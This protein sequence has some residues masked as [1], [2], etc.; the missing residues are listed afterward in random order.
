LKANSYIMLAA[1]TI[2]VSSSCGDE[3]QLP[4]HVEAKSIDTYLEHQELGNRPHLKIKRSGFGKEFILYGSYIPTLTSP[5]SF[6]LRSRI[7]TFDVYADRVIMVESPKGHS[8]AVNTSPILLAEFPI[9]S[10]DADGVIVDFGRGM[11]SAFTVRNVHA[12]GVSAKDSDTSEQFKA[13]LLSASFIKSIEAHEDVLAI[14]QIAQWH[15]Q[16]SELI[17]AEF[18]Y[19]LKEYSQSPQFKKTVYGKH[20][21]VQYFSTP[22]MVKPPTTIPL[23][24]ITKWDLSKP[25][26]FHVSAN[27]P[28]KYK[29]AI[30]D[31][32]LFWNRIFGRD[33]IQVRDLDPAKSAPDPKLNIIQWV[34]WDN[35]ASAYADMVIDHLT[36][37]I[38]QAQIYVR[39]GWVMQSPQKLRNVLQ[40]LF[41]MDESD[42]SKEEEIPI[43]AVFDL[44]QPCVKTMTRS[45]EA[46]DLAQILSRSEVSDETMDVLTADILRAVMAH[47]MGHVLGLRHNLAGSTQGNISLLQRE[48]LLKDYLHTG[49]YQEQNRDFFSRSIM[50]VFS[51]ADDA[52]VGAQI[53]SLLH[54]QARSSNQIQSIYEWDRQAVDFA[55]ANIPMRGNVAFCTDDDM[56]TYQDCQRWD[57][58]HT[59]ILF[60][61]DRLNHLLNEA[62]LTLPDTF[63]FGIDPKRKGGK[64]AIADVT[65]N[66][67][68]VLKLLTQYAKD[69]LQWF[70]EDARS[71]RIEARH[72]AFGPHNSDAITEDR[73]SSQRQQIEVNGIKQTVFGLLPPYRLPNLDSKYLADVFAEQLVRR[74]K[75]LQKARP[76]FNFTDEQ[77]IEAKNMVLAF[78]D[79][80]RTEFVTTLLRMLARARFDDP[81]FQL[82][83]EEALG[84]VAYE[85][86]MSTK[87]PDD[88][89]SHGLLPQFAYDM[90][91]RERAVDILSPSLGLLPDWSFD[92]L[93]DITTEL[94]MLLQLA[95]ARDNNSLASVGFMPR[96][97]RQWVIEQGRLLE[98]IMRISSNS[99]DEDI[100]TK[101]KKAVA[102]SSRPDPAVE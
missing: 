30:V 6:S 47:E 79:H 32:L 37:Q 60:A 48:A 55:Y 100:K 51:A 28:T 62:A 69:L 29:D 99:R 63:I 95:G 14:S 76:D 3:E 64:L 38:L 45:T 93:R 46:T 53:K 102:K 78:F 68:K 2:F 65:L 58:G 41:L 88:D 33:I 98:S 23:A 12:H 10:H 74:V 86:I 40:E 83:I 75:H 15:N 94:K 22:P 67:T 87:P 71:I 91:L 25:I 4:Y 57:S 7:V 5:S 89:K 70:S 49:I 1:L 21:W 96:E 8:I 20:R 59:P 50:D 42:K 19:F 92:N 35:E 9:A 80:L 97:H 66:N 90:A 27:T 34:P 72:Q 13:V 77:A 26:V 85:I 39:S 52:L 73:F 18:R 43:P 36:G 11:N 61:A 56:S 31:G 16:Q 81:N 82:P 54:G 24:Y 17:S 44:D 84:E 101:D